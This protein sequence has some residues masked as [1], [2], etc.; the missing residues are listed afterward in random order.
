[1]LDDRLQRV[2][3]AVSEKVAL[4]DIIDTASGSM[5]ANSNVK[6]SSLT[7]SAV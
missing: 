2:E 7:N 6:T 3:I 4:D 1:V 5:A